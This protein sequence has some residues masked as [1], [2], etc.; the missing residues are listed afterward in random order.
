MSS[1]VPFLMAD[2]SKLTIRREV[3]VGTTE[4]IIERGQHLFVE[5]HHTGGKKN[6][7]KLRML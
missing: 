2:A 5:A 3:L 4:L 1:L 7:L 6:N